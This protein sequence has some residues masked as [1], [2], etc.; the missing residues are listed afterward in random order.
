MSDLNVGISDNSKDYSTV[1]KQLDRERSRANYR[2]KISDA[3]LTKIRQY[4]YRLVYSWTRD[5]KIEMIRSYGE[6]DLL[7]KGASDD[8]INKQLVETLIINLPESELN[9]IV[10]QA[11]HKQNRLMSEVN[12]A[13]KR[14]IGRS[15]NFGGFN[16]FYDDAAAERKTFKG[17]LSDLRQ[18]YGFIASRGSFSG[19]NSLK[20]ELTGILK[21]MTPN[22]IAGYAQSLGIKYFA[23]ESVIG[24]IS[25][26]A[27]KCGIYAAVVAGSYKGMP[28]S[29]DG[30]EID[31]IEQLIGMTSMAWLVGKKA[32]N[33]KEIS[34]LKRRAAIARKEQKARTRLL[35]AKALKTKS[36]DFNEI[37]GTSG[38]A[39]DVARELEY[40]DTGV[41][42]NYSY[43]EL[44]NKAYEL[45]ID[46]NIRKVRIGQLKMM[47]YQKLAAQNKIARD[48][49]KKLEKA[50]RNDRLGQLKGKP[51]KQ[52]I[53]R[54]LY[55]DTTANQNILNDHLKPLNAG[56][57]IGNA[58]SGGSGTPLVEF[59]SKGEIK[60]DAITHAVPVYIVGEGRVGAQVKAKKEDEQVNEDI[61]GD[62]YLEAAK[63]GVTGKNKKALIKGIY[64]EHKRLNKAGD[65][66]NKDARKL[67]KAKINKIEDLQK[68]SSSFKAE[69]LRYSESEKIRNDLA[70]TLG[71]SVSGDAEDVNANIIRRLN[72]LEQT[73]KTEILGASNND[74]LNA[75]KDKIDIA[76]SGAVSMSATDVETDFGKGATDKTRQNTIKDLLNIGNSEP[77]VE[78]KVEEQALKSYSMSYGKIPDDVKTKMFEATPVMVINY[79]DLLEK[80]KGGYGTGGTD[81]EKTS[82]IEKINT[83]AYYRKEASLNKYNADIKERDYTRLFNQLSQEDK[84]NSGIDNMS[85]GASAKD[86]N[87]EVTGGEDMREFLN[88]PSKKLK[89][90]TLNWIDTPSGKISPI[91]PVWITNG[92][93]EYL[94]NNVESGFEN[95]LSAEQSIYSF[96]STSMPL[97]MAGLQSVGTAINAA[98]GSAMA[99]LTAGLVEAAAT[100]AID[101]LAGFTSGDDVTKY[102]T[103]GTGRAGNNISHFIAGD[104]L[105]NK[106]NE[107]L[108]SID[109]NNK[110]FGVK[111]MNGNVSDASMMGPS[112]RSSSMN[113]NLSNGLIKFNRTLDVDENYDNLALKVYPVTPGIN[114]KVDINGTSVSL[115]ELI[116]SMY[117]SLSSLESLMNAEVELSKV[118]AA[119]SPVS[120]TA[121]GGSSRDSLFTDNLNTILRG[122]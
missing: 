41:L 113:V 5:E 42:A 49:N 15:T 16:K 121:S 86:A 82:G 101:S 67:D 60:T 8:V 21:D 84:L 93:T 11:S 62:V 38:K 70:N 23:G 54:D 30:N 106:P 55:Y 18:Q 103:G 53:T 108:I 25:A 7:P 79:D 80:L 73:F 17:A 119:K 100:S 95:L 52:Y 120:S 2:E 1:G 22:E 63:L 24:V 13:V 47:I 90:T 68:R 118:I 105:N 37:A 64:K 97:M 69:F 27:A 32:L 117:G 83:L 58:P 28:P 3:K 107:E 99:G 59:D 35:N 98:A 51:S 34:V 89:T 104:S 29:I 45:G 40:N 10:A 88:T 74:A 4:A 46:F 109:W 78:E 20:K 19:A 48:Q 44:V 31:A 14:N 96:L 12:S 112:E 77:K 61:P 81:D 92:F 111:P 39:K 87:G 26:I 91:Y 94:N 110:K 9:S 66:K 72:T 85:N 65:K 115:M 56:K 75:I 116:Y 76:Y 33:A 50:K 122:D 114:D 102:A 6:I 57:F 43:E 36:K 71:V